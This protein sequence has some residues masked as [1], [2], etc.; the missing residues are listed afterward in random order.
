MNVIRKQ[1][2]RALAW[3]RGDDRDDPSNPIFC[4]GIL[5]IQHLV[6]RLVGD[7]GCEV[8]E[9]QILDSLYREITQYSK[10]TPMDHNRR[11]TAW[12]WG[13]E[14]LSN[15]H[16]CANWGNRQGPK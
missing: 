9:R 7:R 5:R 12:P 4:P 1:G 14:S 16:R 6:I 15:L 13:T 2:I 10:I 3:W 11:F 8:L